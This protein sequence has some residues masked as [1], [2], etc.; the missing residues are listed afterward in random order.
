MHFKG[1]LPVNQ[2]MLDK[3]W[4]DR[5][6]GLRGG[7]ESPREIVIRLQTYTIPT[8]L[9][10]VELPPVIQSYRRFGGTGCFCAEPPV[11]IFIR[12]PCTSAVPKYF[13]VGPFKASQL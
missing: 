2:K 12:V 10:L 7:E 6:C 1:F 5:E 8:F 9:Q 3:T 11:H 4:V 13:S